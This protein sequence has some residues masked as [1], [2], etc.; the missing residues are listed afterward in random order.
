[1]NWHPPSDFQSS[2]FS[3]T[4]RSTSTC[5]ICQI[6]PLQCGACLILSACWLSST[7][8]NSNSA[9]GSSA[10]ASVLGDGRSYSSS[11]RADGGWS[12]PAKNP[13]FPRL[14]RGL[15]YHVIHHFFIIFP[16]MKGG[17]SDVSPI[18]NGHQGKVQR[19]PQSRPYFLAPPG[20]LCKQAA[21]T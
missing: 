19:P 15:P 11:Y 1:M 17:F 16:G 12:G 6:A 3:R 13:H 10:Y 7:D 9:T 18:K 20:G 5:Q 2:A 14:F 21:S 4:C 8:Q